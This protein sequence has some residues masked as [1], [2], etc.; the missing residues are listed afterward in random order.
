MP[1]FVGFC[2]V[3]AVCGTPVGARAFDFFG[4]FGGPETAEPSA[5]TL[6]YDVKFSGFDDSRIERDL[7]DVSNAWRLRRDP[8]SSGVGLARRVEADIPKIAEALWANGYYDASVRAVLADV[9]IAPDGAGSAQAA[10]AA[11]GYRNRALASV[12]YEVTLGPLFHLRHVVVYDAQTRAPIDPS[13]FP[14]G[15]LSPAPDAPARVASLATLQIEWIDD[16]RAKSF[17]LAKIVDTKP[18]IF[19]NENV[20]DVAVT[21][22][23]GPRAGIGK[24]STSGSPGVDPAVI[25]SFIYLEEG[26]PYNPK[27]LADT[28]KSIA[29]IEAIG[30]VKIEEATHLDANGNLPLMIETSERKRHAIG[31]SAMF[32]NVDGPSARISW[33][34]RNLFGG[35]ERL[36]L[37]AQAGLAPFG[38]GA[39]FRSLS[40]LRWSDMVGRVGASFIKP[41][42]WGTRNDLLV[43]VAGIREKTDY[44]DATYGTGAIAV[45]HRFSE[46]FFAQAGVM[47]EGGRTT[48]VW[49]HHTYTLLGFPLSVSY[50][51]TDNTLAPTRGIRATARMTPYVK[52]LPHGVGM[53]ETKGQISGYYA[54]DEDARYILAGRLAAGSIIGPDIQTIPASH[55]LFAGGG[56]SVRGY[57]YRSLSPYNGLGFPTG[58]RSLLEASAEAR[59]KITDTIGIVPFIDAGG[60]FSSPY[61]DFRSRIRMGAGLGLRYYT[62]IGPIR[63]DV[64]TPL[65]PRPGDSRVAVYVGIGESF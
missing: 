25:R 9:T 61:P 12:R 63:L 58:G 5:Q 60:A 59:I 21:I 29:S 64:A 17:P 16:L 34:D 20:V 65:N 40:A 19:H 23:P 31:A 2:G 10:A 62:P 53:L 51:S 14:Q 7:K 36:R 49:G 54:I 37:D 30:G 13:L 32:S 35:A 48:D 28:R 8:P 45:R 15:A 46:N 1:R 57:R 41:A 6:A 50:D 4:L 56:G 44:Y 24:V 33:V 43:D 22:D 11:E 26:E 42:L 39:S 55:R 38:G 3:L 52:A 27:R 47:A 18:V